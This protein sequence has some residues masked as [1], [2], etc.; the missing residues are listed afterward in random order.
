[1][2]ENVKKGADGFSYNNKTGKRFAAVVPMHTFG[3]PCEIDA[4]ADICQRYNIPLVKMLLKVL[5]LIIRKNILVCLVSFSALS[6]NGNK[7][8]TT[9]GGGMILTDDEE[10]GKKS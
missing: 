4:I 1:M 7:V 2:K 5:A 10:V 3:H 8:I 6:F 9:G